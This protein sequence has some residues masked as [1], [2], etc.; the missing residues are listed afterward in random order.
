MVLCELNLIMIT[1]E[2]LQKACSTKKS[3][4]EKYIEPLNVVG[5]YYEL[6]DNNKRIAGFLAQTM[7]ESGAFTVTQENLNYSVAGLRK[8]FNKYFPTDELARQYAKQP[9]KIA[10]R[11]YANRMR[12]GDE[13]SGDGWKFR[14][15]GLIQ[16]TGRDNYTKLANDLEMTLD[17][18][19][20]YLE[21]PNGA[22][23][24]AG[25]FWDNNDLNSYCD[26][27][28]FIGLT[29]RINGGTIGLEDRQQYY[30]KILQLLK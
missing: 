14:G 25:W 4:L 27:G 8:I 15:R 28:D 13:N 16:L 24:S 9:E 21:T 11:V 2:L 22:T 30:N 18:T 12:N 29:K 5:E 1:I 19:V 3:I 7:H 23:A 6:F 20:K 10:N 26:K 17:E